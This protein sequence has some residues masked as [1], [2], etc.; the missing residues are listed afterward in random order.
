[1]M[2]WDSY[3]QIAM[4]YQGSAPQDIR[5][6]EG[7][8]IGE[9]INWA[10]RL[11]NEPSNRKPPRVIADRAREMADCVGL[12]TSVLDEGNIRDLKM[13]A[14][15]GVSQGS[16]EPPR[17][18]VLKHMGNPGSP[19]ILAFLLSPIPYCHPPVSLLRA[20]TFPRSP[21]STL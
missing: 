2:N 13:G 19:K 1:M 18:V 7:A 20:V 15:L 10:R 12:T 8:I 9:S 16:E 4:V 17:L 11:I 14:L 6:V 21:R 5:T 3:W